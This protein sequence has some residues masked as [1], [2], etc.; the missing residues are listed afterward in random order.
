M[1][2]N[3]ASSQSPPTS[4]FPV[5]PDLGLRMIP[6]VR[7]LWLTDLFVQ[8][9]ALLTLFHVLIS[10][11]QPLLH[12]LRIGHT[13]TVAY[14]MRAT[15]VLVTSLPDPRPGCQQIQDKFWSTL[16][17]HRCGDCIFSGH[18]TALTVCTLYWLVAD[19]GRARFLRWMVVMCFVGGIWAILA[20]RAHY[21]VDILLAVYIV[22]PLWFAHAH[23]WN[24]LIV[25]QRRFEPLFAHYRPM[26]IWPWH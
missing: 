25:P 6:A 7:E 26:R 19:V 10:D 21:T 2:S 11:P 9:P 8:V 23:L 14:L 15:T 22:V 1:A 20:N 12:T 4:R 3:Y 13:L 18:T 17:L 24:T 5:L 16:V